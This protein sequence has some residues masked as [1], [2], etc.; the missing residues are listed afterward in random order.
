MIGDICA[1][2]H[3]YFAKDEQK[4]NGT[5]KV[6]NGNIVADFIA[7]GQYFRVI[8]STFN[9]GVYRYPATSLTDEEFTGSVWALSI[10]P[11]LVKLAEEITEYNESDMAKPTMYVSESFGGYSYTKATDSNGAAIG[12]QTAFAGRLRKWRKMP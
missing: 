9:D 4:H 2:I 1:H 5:F 10:P 7:D 8:G 12:W 3:N 11:D 6:E